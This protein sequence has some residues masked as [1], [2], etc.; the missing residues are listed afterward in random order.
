VT[1]FRN[2]LPKWQQIAKTIKGRIESGEYPPGRLISER[3]MVEEFGV[4]GGTARKAIK[5]LRDE[6]LIFTR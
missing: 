6:G 4:A 5:A 2:Y 1:E 3:W